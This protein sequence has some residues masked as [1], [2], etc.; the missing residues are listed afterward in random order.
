MNSFTQTMKLNSKSRA[1]SVSKRVDFDG[2]FSPD[3][4]GISITRLKE[5]NMKTSWIFFAVVKF[6]RWIELK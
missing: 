4:T 2:I 6:I 1:I 5:A 3:I